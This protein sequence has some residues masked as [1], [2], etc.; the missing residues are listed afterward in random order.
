MDAA[1]V[2]NCVGCVVSGNFPK[3]GRFKGVLVSSEHP[4]SCFLAAYQNE[5]N[6]LPHAQIFL[7]L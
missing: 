3:S 6:L 1:E 4:E 5:V 7:Y 2:A